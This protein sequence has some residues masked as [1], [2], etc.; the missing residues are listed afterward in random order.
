MFGRVPY[1]IRYHGG[2]TRRGYKDRMKRIDDHLQNDLE[3]TAAVADIIQE[4]RRVRR[5]QPGTDYKQSHTFKCLIDAVYRVYDDADQYG[6]LCDMDTL[7]MERYIGEG[8]FIRPL[9]Y[10][11]DVD[12]HPLNGR[13][14]NQ[15]QS[16]HDKMNN[17]A[18]ILGARVISMNIHGD[19]L[20]W[21]I[22]DFMNCLSGLAY[23]IWQGGL[24]CLRV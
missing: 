21:L 5:R 19:R 16:I 13:V 24:D 4:Y 23:F 3:L 9:Q 11:C 22:D 18:R 1:Y 6:D 20:K 8:V 17:V 12:R 15:F 2:R 10:L 7:R 14:P